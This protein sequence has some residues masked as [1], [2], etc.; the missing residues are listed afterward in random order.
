MNMNNIYIHISHQSQKKYTLIQ[1]TYPCSQVD[2]NCN[3]KFV[4]ARH[5]IVLDF[6]KTFFKEILQFTVLV[7]RRRLLLKQMMLLSAQQ[8][9]I[10]IIGNGDNETNVMIK[11]SY[12]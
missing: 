5:K 1:L 12:S 6:L 2:C 4:K 11:S 8:K 10:L 7:L 3:L 9:Y